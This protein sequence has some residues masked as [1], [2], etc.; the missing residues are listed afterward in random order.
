MVLALPL[1]GDIV[2][3]PEQM[4]WDFRRGNQIVGVDWD[5]WMHFMVVAKTEESE[6]LVREIAAWL[7]M[8]RWAGERNPVEPGTGTKCAV[9]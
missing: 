7:S 4:F 2:I 8:S 3:G 1:A 6:P 5:I 9:E